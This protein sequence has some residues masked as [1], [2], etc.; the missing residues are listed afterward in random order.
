MNQQK[1][2][3]ATSRVS[4]A[5]TRRPDTSDPFSTA[6][7][8]QPGASNRTSLAPVYQPDTSNRAS[9]PPVHR[10]KANKGLLKFILLSWI[11]FGIYGLV[12]MSSVSDDINIIAS[13]YDGRKTMHY[14]LLF[15]LVG[16]ITLGI[17]SIVWYHNISNRIGIELRRR[18]ILY[19]FGA[20]SY[21]LWNVL[22]SLI[23]IGPFVYRHKLFKATNKLC[24]H[25]NV[26]G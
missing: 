12:V 5:L 19:S 7:V 9:S 8:R 11:T 17:A 24:R 6:P 23:L 13:R 10:L 18:G 15:F 21:W 20:G 22:G 26:N 2:P 3:G 25:Y 16:P 14:C 4:L 1:T